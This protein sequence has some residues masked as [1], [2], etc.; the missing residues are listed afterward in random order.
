MG[1]SRVSD[2]DG[3]FPDSLSPV[4][5]LMVGKREVIEKIW[6]RYVRVRT[7]V[8]PT[9]PTINVVTIIDEYTELI[10]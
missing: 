5:T 8:G 6:V 4:V 10:V 9:G 1:V 7:K 3:K 2:C